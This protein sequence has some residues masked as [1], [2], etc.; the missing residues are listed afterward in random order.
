MSYIPSSPLPPDGN[1]PIADDRSCNHCGYNLRGLQ[2]DGMCPECGTP[3]SRSI[4]G[5]FLEYCDPNWLDRLHLGVRMKLW[6]IVLGILVGFLAGLLAGVGISPVLGKLLSIAG[7]AVGLYAAILITTQ[8]PRISLEE[9]TLTLRR[10]VRACAVATFGAALV[11]SISHHGVVVMIT[12][13]VALAGVVQYLGEFVYFRRFARRIP[14]GAL[15]R[16][17]TTVMWGMIISYGLVLFGAVITAITV[18]GGGGPAF[19]GPAPAGTTAPTT[20]APAITPSGAGFMGGAALMC[21]AGVVLLVF[22]LWYIR[23]LCKYRDAFRLAADKA[24]GL[25]PE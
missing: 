15:E 7:A 11:N 25:A 2:P 16:A 13:L 14:D 24:R 19:P 21:G 6:N 23:L 4:H 10:V 1:A 8:E 18:F 9:D 17:T 22:G 20:T 3:I 12:A 5:D